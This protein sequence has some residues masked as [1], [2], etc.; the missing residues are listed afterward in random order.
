MTGISPARQEGPDRV[1]LRMM[2]I[3]LIGWGCLNWGCVPPKVQIHSA[4]QFDPS[5]I[6][7]V[8]VLPF[9]AVQTPQRESRSVRESIGEIEDVRRLFQLPG[10]G[11]TV[12]GEAKREP[13]VVSDTDARRITEKVLAA[14][15]T[16]PALRVIGPREALSVVEEHTQKDPPTLRALAQA[17][18]NGLQVDGVLTGLVRTYRE[19]EGSKFGAYPAAVGFEIYL[20]RA[21]DG[22]LLWTGEYYEKQKPLT[23]DVVGFFEKGGGFV[24]ADE[25]AE[26]G[27]RKVMNAFPVSGDG[28]PSR[29]PANP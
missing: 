18:G 21:S 17:V 29:L 20:L 14:L 4:P 10:T 28:Q 24:T 22:A 9:Q 23:E 11:A 19:R 6:S 15:K 2:V 25:L 5:H 12:M 8:A 1:S 3:G 13:Y 27:V 16:R 7:S 26:L